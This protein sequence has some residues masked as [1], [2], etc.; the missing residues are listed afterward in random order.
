MG[1]SWYQDQ[2]MSGA[3]A[4]FGPSQFSN[5]WQEILKPQ[6]F[7]QLYLI[8]EAASAHHAWV[9]G[10]LESVVQ[11]TYL[12]FKSLHTANPTFQAY[13]RAME[14]LSNDSHDKFPFYPLPLEMPDSQPKGSEGE[15]RDRA[16]EWSYADLVATLSQVESLFDTDLLQYWE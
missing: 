15:E 14:L 4:Y 13:I 9:V 10:A 1:F 7:G 8:G 6:S 2:N 16:E 3:F 12:M 11:A 5:M